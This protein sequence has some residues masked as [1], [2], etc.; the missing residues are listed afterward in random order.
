MTLEMQASGRLEKMQTSLDE[1]GA[2]DYQLP[3]D[4]QRIPLNNLI[5]K[6]ISLEHL[7]DIHCIHCGRRSKRVLARATTPVLPSCPSATAVL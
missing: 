6:R 3:L 7:G 4:E 2:V 5:G 1:N